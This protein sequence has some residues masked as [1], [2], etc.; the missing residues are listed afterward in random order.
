MW[1]T[2]PLTMEQY[3]HHQQQRPH[4]RR[5]A[6]TPLPSEQKQFVKPQIF[7]QLAF[8]V[9]W[10]ERHAPRSHTVTYMTRNLKNAREAGN[11]PRQVPAPTTNFLAPE[12]RQHR[13][14]DHS[15]RP[16]HHSHHHHHHHHQQQ[17]HHHQ[18][19]SHP[20]SHPPRYH[21]HH[22]PDGQPRRNRD[23]DRP[24]GR[25]GG[26]EDPD[27]VAQLE[28]LSMAM[29]TVDNGFENQWWYQGPRETTHHASRSDG[30]VG[31][32]D[33]DLDDDDDDDVRPL[34]MDDALLLAAAEPPSAGL[35]GFHHHHHHHL[36]D[37]HYEED[38]Y[39]DGDDDETVH[40][41]LQDW[42][43]ASRHFGEWNGSG[44]G[45]GNGDWWNGDEDEEDDGGV[46][47]HGGGGG[48]GTLQD[49]VSPLSDRSGTLLRSLTTR[50]EEL[51]MER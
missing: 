27:R 16:H 47:P 7:V 26:G 39:E 37:D 4:R 46:V 45:S 31:D 38:N 10:S 33:H 51:W 5:S 22:Q 43:G 3:D 24:R 35:G 44:S 49:L 1:R 28:S 15:G 13:P 29:M 36:Q 9:S 48:H 14:R 40:G 21:P 17:Q 18:S 30:D 23:P 11:F 42:L 12:P 2:E 41:T 6:H 19:Q 8:G 25:G 50:S 32:H 34:S 20:Y